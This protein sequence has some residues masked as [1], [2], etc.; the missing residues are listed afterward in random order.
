MTRKKNK[1]FT[2]VFAT[3]FGAGQ[4]YMGFMKQGLSIMT[5]TVAIIAFG[6]WSGIGIVFLALPV[7]WFYAFFDAMNKMTMPDDVFEKLEDQYIFLPNA[8]YKQ[9][10]SLII[11]YEKGIAIIFILIGGSV[12][13]EYMLES[14]ADMAAVTGLPRLADFASRLR[15]NGSRLL[16]SFVIIVI[17]IRMIMGK[18]KALELEENRDEEKNYN[19]RPMEYGNRTFYDDA[20]M[21][22][23]NLA[24]VN[25]GADTVNA[26]EVTDVASD[27]D[28]TFEFA[29]I[30]TDETDSMEQKADSKEQKN[31]NA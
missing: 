9:L 4:M 31:E 19:F 30:E 12:L 28:Y 26:A 25:N 20:A 23:N 2:F 17:G 5:A 22:S 18:K 27:Y 21:K 1:F 14:I 29:T 15:W 11:K 24:G 16:F 6:G 8:D 10:K 3:V 7:L 13:G